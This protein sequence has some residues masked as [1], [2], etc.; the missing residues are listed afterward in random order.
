MLISS[1]FH[2]S[3][4]SPIV[5]QWQEYWEV[6]NFYD[7][8]WKGFLWFKHWRSVRLLSSFIRWCHVLYLSR[9]SN[10]GQ[11]YELCL[12]LFVL[13]FHLCLKLHQKDDEQPITL[14]FLRHCLQLINISWICRELMCSSENELLLF[15][16]FMAQIIVDLIMH[17]FS[18][19]LKETNLC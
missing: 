12:Y 14:H 3:K 18:N 5:G 4:N 19:H 9:A 8:E 13:L 11:S 16:A 7:L 6:H 15:L 2:L 17:E 1:K 10:T